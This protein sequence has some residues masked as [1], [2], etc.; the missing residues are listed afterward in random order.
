MRVLR[1]LDP[2]VNLTSSHLSR[3][4]SEAQKLRLPKG[5]KKE[6]K[7]KGSG[8]TRRRMDQNGTQKTSR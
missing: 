5:K 2:C 1:L 4:Q 3:K 8:L 6:C 7:G